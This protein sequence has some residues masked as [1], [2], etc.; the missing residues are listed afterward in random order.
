M[1]QT[2]FIREPQG[3]LMATMPHDITFLGKNDYKLRDTR[4]ILT[5]PE[6][7]EAVRYCW[8]WQKNGNNG[9]CRT[10]RRN[11]DN[12]RL[13]AVC[14]AIS[15]QQRAVRL[16]LRPDHPAA[17]Y[18]IQNSKAYTFINNSH[19]EVIL[20]YSEGHVYNIQ[21]P[22]RLARWSTH[23]IRVRACVSLFNSGH[24]P[25]QIQHLLRWKSITWRDYLRD[26][27]L[28][29]VS[30]INGINSL[31]AHHLVKSLEMAKKQP[32]TTV[33]KP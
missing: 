7:V 16:G 15:I 17:I 21:C 18:R 31:L 10:V 8:R 22:V 11:V 12:P 27:S 6:L 5:N 9:E 33:T 29:S 32:L 28:L 25:E 23:S 1:K 26:C 2:F 14:A 13:C 19:V 3:T 30:Q 4:T 24:I 20:Q